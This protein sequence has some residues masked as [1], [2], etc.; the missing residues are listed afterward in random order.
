MRALLNNNEVEETK[1]APQRGLTETGKVLYSVRI[2]VV[3]PCAFSTTEYFKP[4]FY[5]YFRSLRPQEYWQSKGTGVFL[6]I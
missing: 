1:Q 5:F 3:N 4:S 6:Q 2:P